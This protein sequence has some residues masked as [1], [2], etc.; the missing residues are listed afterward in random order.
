VC[1]TEVP[2]EHA[3]AYLGVIARILPKELSMEITRADEQSIQ[4]VDGILERF[5]TMKTER[6]EAI[7]RLQRLQGSIECQVI[8]GQQVARA[9]ERCLRAGSPRS[10]SYPVRRLWPPRGSDPACRFKSGDQLRSR[11]LRSAPRVVVRGVRRNIG[12]RSGPAAAV[13]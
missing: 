12:K 3:P 2:G 6:D 7:E 10:P 11:F 4:H 9:E 5:R 1:H 8:D 13:I